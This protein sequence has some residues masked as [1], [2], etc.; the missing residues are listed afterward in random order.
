MTLLKEIENLM[1]LLQRAF[2]T[3]GGLALVFACPALVFAQSGNSTNHYARQGGEYAPAGALPGDQSNP[4]LSINSGGGLLVWQD[5]ITDGDGFGIKRRSVWTKIFLPSLEFS[6]LICSVAPATRKIRRWHCLP[7]GGAAFVWQ[8][9]PLSFQ[10]IVGRFYSSSNTWITQDVPI[11]TATNHYQANPAIAALANG[12]LIVT[13]ASFG[14][15]NTDGY[16]GV[17]AQVMSPT[18][19]KKS[20][21]SFK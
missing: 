9:G 2:I 12:N 14:Q 8:S 21:A 17:Y 1:S 18:R 13:W 11:N 15:D 16:Q 20:A 4:F 19:P 6:G 5:N 3:L 7:G 10:H